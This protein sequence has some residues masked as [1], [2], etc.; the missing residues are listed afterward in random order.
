MSATQSDPHHPAAPAADRNA[1]AYSMATV[2]NLAGDAPAAAVMGIALA[3]QPPQLL[4]DRRPYRGGGGRKLV[5]DTKHDWEKAQCGQFCFLHHEGSAA[6]S[7]AVKAAAAAGGAASGP[8]PPEKQ[9]EHQ[10]LLRADSDLRVPSSGGG[11][12]AAAE[13][14]YDDSHKLGQLPATAIAGNDITSSCLYSAGLTVASG[15]L[16]APISSSILCFVLWLFRDIY[17]EVCSGLPMNGGTYNALLNTTSKALAALASV[18]SLIS[19]TATA[20]TSASS[21][22]EYLHYQWEAVSVLGL[23]IGILVFFAVL[24]ILG[25]TE[26]AMVASF[27]FIV[28]LTT[29]GILI[30][31]GLVFVIRDNGQTL[32]N[33]YHQTTLAAN[34][35]GDQAK[36]IFFGYCSALLGVTG[37]ES[38]ANYIE[39]QK[40][41]VFPKTL[42]NMWLAVSVINPVLILLALGVLGVDAVAS[43]QDFVLAAFAERS[44]GR[45]LKIVVVIDATMVL[46][47]AVLTSYVGV[48]GLLRRM[49]MDSLMPHFF[50]KV[51]KWRKTNH[52]IIIT[53][54]LLT[55]S[56]RLLVDDM[57]TLGG[58][59]AISFLGVMTLF[60]VA[61]LALKFKRAGL[62]RTPIAPLPKVILAIMFV[63]A[64]IIGNFL[65][66]SRNVAFFCMYFVLFA[67]VVLAS[68][69]KVQLFRFV[70][71]VLRDISPRAST[72]FK[73]LVGDIRATPVVFF[74][75]T[76]QISRLNKM[77]LYVMANEETSH[78]YVVHCS[79]NPQDPIVSQFMEQLE[80]TCEKLDEVY[81]KITVETVLY[82]GGFSPR[83]VDEISLELGVAKNFMF[84]T[85]PSDR[86]PHNI[87]RFGGLRVISY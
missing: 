55:V 13:A 73:E 38:S 2:P 51:N 33:T 71:S 49:A 81:P 86:F 67:I 74:T 14:M 42:R 48:T 17:A 32:R 76:S 7:D 56:L 8:P 84:I 9:G 18:L 21:A 62:P 77:L 70:G 28:H 75:R 52:W 66:S 64:G 29:M 44:A 4:R 16:M 43:D 20:V 72:Y 12:V 60:G 45:W 19:Y 58:V 5:S 41:G 80:T 68:I 57:Q 3:A 65:K 25:V 39:E 6:S 46:A 23:I 69:L 15:G 82:Q 53:Y 1:S 50:L 36:N 85:C 34:P 26:S 63:V 78:V 79:E 11:V 10:G 22:A 59:Y 54:C 35:W 24:N 61:N 87:S 30:V 27:L 31:A 47:G 37:F 40:P 83:T